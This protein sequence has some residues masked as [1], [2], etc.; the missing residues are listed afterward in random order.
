MKFKIPNEKFSVRQKKPPRSAEDH[1]VSRDFGDGGDGYYFK[2]SITF[3]SQ[4][5]SCLIDKMSDKIIRV[6]FLANLTIVFRSP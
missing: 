1:F 3:S 5:V 4:N 2:G 6:Y